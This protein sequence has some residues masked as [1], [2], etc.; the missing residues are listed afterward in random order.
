MVPTGAPTDSAFH[1]LAGHLDQGDVLN[2]AGNADFHDTRRR[3]D[4]L[5]ASGR[6]F[7]GVG[8]LAAPRGPGMARP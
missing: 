1:D 8:V 5:T 2:D 3:S 4:D 7:L 6:H